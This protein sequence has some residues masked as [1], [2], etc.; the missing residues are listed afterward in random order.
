MLSQLYDRRK[1]TNAIISKNCFSNQTTFFFYYCK[2]VSEENTLRLYRARI[3]NG[4]H[5]VMSPLFAKQYSHKVCTMAVFW[6]LAEKTDGF[7]SFVIE[8]QIC[9]A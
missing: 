3:I 1:E 8:L 5:G 6:L 4:K 2:C 7:N 9:R